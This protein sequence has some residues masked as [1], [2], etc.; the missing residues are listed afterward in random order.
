MTIARCGLWTGPKWLVAAVI[1]AGSS[2]RVLA[3]PPTDESRWGL[4]QY[5]DGTYGG[6]ELVVSES[7]ARSD[8]V[9]RLAL[10]RG[11]TVWIVPQPCVRALQTVAGLAAGPPS[12]MAALLART[13]ATA[14][15]RPYL[16]RL[17]P[18]EER[19]LNLL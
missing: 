16:R 8:A 11:T 12:R 3:L 1:H 18:D 10:A 9:A 2:T 14:L 13:P 4:L 6:W 7:M 5:L 15:L 19:Q 17:L